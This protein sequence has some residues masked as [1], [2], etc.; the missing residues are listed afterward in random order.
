MQLKAG[1]IIINSIVQKYKA[2]KIKRS[3]GKWELPA[4]FLQKMGRQPKNATGG[5]QS[6]RGYE[7]I[8]KNQR[9]FNLY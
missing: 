6:E 5:S 9:F 3:E 4:L 2:V 8:Q 7:R 1:E